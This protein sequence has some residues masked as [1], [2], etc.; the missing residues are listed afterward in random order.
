MTKSYLNISLMSEQY[1]DFKGVISS[2]SIET[3]LINPNIF[4]AIE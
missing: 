4:R 1:K 2:N 3:H